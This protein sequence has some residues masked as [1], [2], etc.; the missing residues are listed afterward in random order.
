M[1]NFLKKSIFHV[2]KWLGFFGL[3]RVLTRGRLRILCYHGLATTDEGDFRPKLFIDADLFEKRLQFLLRHKYPVLHLEQ[4]LQL[5]QSGAMPGCATVITVDD[6]FNSFFRSAWPLLQRYSCPATLYVYSEACLN[7]EPIFRLAVQYMFWKTR[8]ADLDLT[9]LGLQHTGTVSLRDGNVN[10]LVWDL[11][12][13]G[14]SEPNDGGRERMARVLGERLG[15]DYEQIRRQRSLT[16]M[17]PEQLREVSVGG[18]VDVQLHTHHHRFPVEPDAAEC[19]I[20]M[21]KQAIEPILGKRLVHF[22]YPSGVWCKEHWPVLQKLGIQSAVTCDAGLN[23]RKTPLLA[24][25]RFLDANDMSE[26]EFAAEMSGFSELLRKLKS[27]LPLRKTAHG[28]SPD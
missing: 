21:N 13:L 9:G 2:N 18:I 16:I 12:R 6:G 24:L 8:K 7:Q 1:R 20:A 27:V 28:T 17:S 11:I 5:M 25:N 10:N 14:E 4:A 15:V 23:N 3:A 19:E 22:C 26:I